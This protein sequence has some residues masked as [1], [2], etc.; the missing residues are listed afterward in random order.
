MRALTSP[1]MVSAPMSQT[2]RTRPARRNDYNREQRE[3]GEQSR[4]SVVKHRRIAKE[5]IGDDDAEHRGDYQA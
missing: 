3:S 5:G 2:A 1:R 4:G